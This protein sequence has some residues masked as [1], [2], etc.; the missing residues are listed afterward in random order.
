MAFQS[1]SDNLVPG[2]A[3]GTCDVFVYDRE[4]GLVLSKPSRFIEG[5][6]EQLLDTWVVDDE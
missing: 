3:N 4:T 6:P 1:W 5:M 2:D